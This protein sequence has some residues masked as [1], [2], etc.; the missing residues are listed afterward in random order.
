MNFDE[1]NVS[2]SFNKRR[3]V[4]ELMFTGPLATKSGAEKCSYLL[5]CVGQQGRDIHNTWTLTNDQKK[6]PAF[7]LSKFEEYCEPRKNVTLER[8]KFFSRNQAVHEPIDAYVTDLP[9]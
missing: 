1:G 9:R 6:D 7:L 3:Q 2:D 8:H 5:L 4:I